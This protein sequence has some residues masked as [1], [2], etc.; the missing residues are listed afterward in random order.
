[1]KVLFLTHRRSTPSTRYRVT[2]MLPLLSLECE[3]REIPSSVLGRVRLLKHARRFDTV[4]VQKRLVSGLFLRA[5]RRAAHRLVYDFDDAVMIDSS[6]RRKRFA[7]MVRAA[8]L[9]LAGNSFLL[10]HA[11]E[12]GA[13]RA[14]ILPTG[15]D[16]SR[17]SPAV[18]DGTV[19][20]WI[21]TGGNL[22]YLEEIFPALAEAFRTEPRLRLRIISDRFPRKAPLPIDRCP[23]S[24]ETEG[25][26]LRAIGIGLA[27]L[28][29]DS[30]S[31]G[32]CGLKILQYL[33][34]RVPTV[35]S[36]VGIQSS[37]LRDAGLLPRSLQEWTRSILELS[38]DAELRSRLGVAGRRRVEDDF[39]IP[40]I[41][42]RLTRLLRGL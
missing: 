23:W 30:W 38:R 32:K 27:P 40:R 8:D 2:Q 17:Y 5:L 4:V 37:M 35:A 13:R 12:A 33:A 7:A 25:E 11:V 28:P 36:P 39:A 6:T 19:L 41:A 20:G 14:E 10:E 42:E 26:A 34:C 9:T 24:E 31:R 15:V 16:P 29:D 3:A 22:P 21:G 18:G 1:M